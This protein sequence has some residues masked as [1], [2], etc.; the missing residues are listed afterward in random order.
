MS[1]GRGGRS[2]GWQDLTGAQ[3]RSRMLAVP[4]GWAWRC[5]ARK[6][7]EYGG[8]FKDLLIH[9]VGQISQIRDGF[10]QKAIQHPIYSLF[11]CQLDT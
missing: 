3:G 1:N 2:L 8:N 4:A 6:V 9:F 7:G 10:S 11:F 5:V